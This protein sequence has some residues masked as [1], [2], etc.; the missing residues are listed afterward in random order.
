MM[1][2]VEVKLTPVIRI[3]DDV[4]QRLQALATPLVDTP[5]SVIKRLLD[6]HQPE[7]PLSEPPTPLSRNEIDEPPAVATAKVA[8][9]TYENRANPHVTI[10]LAGCS[11]LRKRGGVHRHGQGSYEGHSTLGEAGS[12]A[13]RTGLPIKLCGYCKSTGDDVARQLVIDYVRAH[14][15]R[16]WEEAEIKH[17]TGVGKDRVRTL[18]TGHPEIDQDVLAAGR[19]RWKSD[20]GSVETDPVPHPGHRIGALVLSAEPPRRLRS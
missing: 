14:P 12:Y 9:E 8:Y 5:G 20:G 16:D 19:V 3:P 10:H 17:A 4:F 7:A 18:M 2:A 15:G 13:R 6:L 11:Q 1:I